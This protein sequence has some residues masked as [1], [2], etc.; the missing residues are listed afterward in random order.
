MP[1]GAGGHGDQPVGAFFN[2]FF[3]KAVVDD[4]MQRN[5]A[6]ADDQSVN[7]GNPVKVR[8]E[9][10]N[11]AETKAAPKDGDGAASDGASAEAVES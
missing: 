6:A 1:P 9:G 5:A 2:G 3:G 7:N 8:A 11:G 4:I 10:E